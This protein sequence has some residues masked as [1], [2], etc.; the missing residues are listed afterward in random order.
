MWTLFVAWCGMCP[1]PPP[2]PP[3]VLPAQ[4]APQGVEK[5]HYE[6]KTDIESNDRG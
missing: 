3:E 2:P 1:P 6:C 5:V 4:N